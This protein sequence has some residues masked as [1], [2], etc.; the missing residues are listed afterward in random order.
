MKNDSPPPDLL[1]DDCQFGLYV[2]A[3]C[4]GTTG[5]VR[6]YKA[7]HSLLNKTVAIIVPTAELDHHGI[8][9]FLGAVRR[10][11]LKGD[12]VYDLGDRGGRL[13]AAVGYSEDD[14]PL[15]DLSQW[16]EG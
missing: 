1:P 8:A 3:S 13:F 14:G 5:L 10:A 6:I 2:V 15:V 12:P 16:D 4:L 7:K 11:T 9:K